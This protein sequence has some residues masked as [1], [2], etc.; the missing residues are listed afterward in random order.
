MKKA[1]QF[2]EKWDYNSGK[3]KIPVGV[4]YKEKRKTLEDNWPQ[5]KDGR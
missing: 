5:L 3:G 1:L 2:A 4:I